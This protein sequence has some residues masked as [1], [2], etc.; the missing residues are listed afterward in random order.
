AF[1]RIAVVWRALNAEE[2]RPGVVITEPKEGE[3]VRQTGPT[4]W[5]GT[6]GV[7]PSEG[8]DLGLRSSSPDDS[9]LDVSQT[10]AIKSAN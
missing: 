8:K 5:K 9:E 2:G 7:E 1:E 4:D 10:D 6:K 3:E